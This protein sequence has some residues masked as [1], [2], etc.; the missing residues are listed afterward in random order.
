MTIT[1]EIKD[2][3][4]SPDINFIKTIILSQFDYATDIPSVIIPYEENEEDSEKEFF[5]FTEK[6]QEIKKIS[7]E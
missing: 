3:L 4:D 2:S 1:F 5:P 6:V 7:R